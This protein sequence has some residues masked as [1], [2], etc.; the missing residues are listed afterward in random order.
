MNDRKYT[1]NDPD[2]VGSI[3][4]EG[5]EHKIVGW[6][7]TSKN[8]QAPLINIKLCNPRP[9]PMPEAKVLKEIDDDIPF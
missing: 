6:K 5:V 2:F 7:S 1:P 4:V 3:N 8:K 9:V